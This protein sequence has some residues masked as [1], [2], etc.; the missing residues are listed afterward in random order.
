[1]SSVEKAINK[2]RNH[3]SVILINPRK[4]TMSNSIPPE[5]VKSTKEIF[6]EIF[7]TI[8][9]KCLIKAEFPNELQLADVTPIF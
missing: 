4:T 8:F 5:L 1:M 7:K 3:P 6:W 9:N 2:Y